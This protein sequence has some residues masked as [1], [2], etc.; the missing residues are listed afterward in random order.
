MCSLPRDTHKVSDR[1]GLGA[2]PVQVSLWF[3][4]AVHFNMSHVGWFKLIVAFVFLA[5]EKERAC[6]LGPRHLQTSRTQGHVRTV[7]GTRV[8]SPEGTCASK[9]ELLIWN[10]RHSSGSV[11]VCL[12]VDVVEVQS[13]SPRWHKSN[14][15]TRP[16]P[17]ECMMYSKCIFNALDLSSLLMFYVWPVCEIFV[18]IL[19]QWATR[20]LGY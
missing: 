1:P 9:C 6:R 5:E 18:H 20:A 15:I 14:Y 2:E 16:P 4:F 11:W 7:Q 19:S 10:A 13:P 17:R 12:L 8:I 3:L